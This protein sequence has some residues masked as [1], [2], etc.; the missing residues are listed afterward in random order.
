MDSE[1]HGFTNSSDAPPFA[2]VAHELINHPD[3]KGKEKWMY[4]YLSSKPTGWH[5][6]IRGIITQT[7]DKYE[8]VK[9]GL[10]SLESMGLLSRK[11]G[12]RKFHYTLNPM[13][14]FS[15]E[16]KI[17]S[18]S[19]NKGKSKKEEKEKRTKRK[20]ASS[21]SPQDKRLTKAQYAKA[22]KV[23]DY[24]NK[25]A[26]RNITVLPACFIA[27]IKEGHSIKDF[28]AVVDIKVA[29]WAPDPKMKRYLHPATL[30]NGEKF[31]QYMDE[32]NELR[33]VSC[34]IQKGKPDW[35]KTGKQPDW[36]KR[37]PTAHEVEYLPHRNETHE[38][39][40]QRMEE[41]EDAG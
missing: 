32:V 21:L 4:I 15:N 3:I 16:C 19:N 13:S 29:Q 28:C 40:L 2:M 30:F 37:R 20:T 23:L 18:Y 17:N 6:S 33:A 25:K 26:K 10:K 35:A 36:T 31:A 1:S 14:G 12:L 7:G 11:R 9:A 5:F 39:W 27:R 34:P 38:D 24:L 8:S 41:L 22:R